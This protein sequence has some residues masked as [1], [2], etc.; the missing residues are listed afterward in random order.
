[1]SNL[2]ENKIE[3]FKSCPNCIINGDL[4]G[5]FG[6]KLQDRSINE[7][8][9]LNCDQIGSGNSCIKPFRERL[10]VNF[11]QFLTG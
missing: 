7:F 2:I 3:L 6:M 10:I 5:L 4:T 1:M 9:N 8:F 11:L